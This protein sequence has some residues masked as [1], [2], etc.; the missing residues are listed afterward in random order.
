MAGSKGFLSFGGIST[1]GL[2]RTRELTSREIQR[3]VV[4]G[5]NSAAFYARRQV[6]KIIAAQVDRP[7]PRLAVQRAVEIDKAK[8]S[9]QA[10]RTVLR[11]SRIQGSI[12]ARHEFGF[13]ARGLVVP[14]KGRGTDRYGNVHKSQRGSRLDELLNKT[15]IDKRPR[16][17]KAKRVMRD[18]SGVRPPAKPRPRVKAFFLA[19]DGALRRNGGFFRAGLFRRIDGNRKIQQITRVEHNKKYAPKFN[20][21]K[22]LR[23][24]INAVLKSEIQSSIDF[25]IARK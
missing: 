20:I 12:L 4:T 5:M 16:K 11:L 13:T 9:D 3:A 24:E 25:R 8:P 23:K 6:P 19:R 10:P 15:V 17:R 1:K 14:V 21:R 7:S 18:A 2:Q 22:A